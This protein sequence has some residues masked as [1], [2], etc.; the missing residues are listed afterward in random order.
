MFTALLMMEEKFFGVFQQKIP[1]LVSDIK[2]SH[3]KIGLNKSLKQ[4]ETTYLSN[5][6]ITDSIYRPY[7]IS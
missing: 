5:A 4:W 2:S 6:E 3:F 7:L 1:E